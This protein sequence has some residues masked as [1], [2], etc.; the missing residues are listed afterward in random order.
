MTDPEKL[1][2]EAII[3][4]GNNINVV[5]MEQIRQTYNNYAQKINN[6]PDIEPKWTINM[7]QYCRDVGFLLWMTK[8]LSEKLNE[9]MG[10][11]E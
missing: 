1:Y 9:V 5:M 8:A 6:H 7:D 4:K 10:K 11:H 3:V 2:D